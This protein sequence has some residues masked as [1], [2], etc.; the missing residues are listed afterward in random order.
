MILRTTL[1]FILIVGLQVQDGFAQVTRIRKNIL[2][3]SATELTSLRK[4]VEV[5]KSRP[6]SDPTSWAFQLAVHSTPAT[7]TNA[8][9]NQCEHGTIWFF[10]WHR[11]YIFRFEAILRKASGDPNLTLPYW[12]WTNNRSLP[13]SFRQPV[14]GG[15][16]NPLFH[17]ERDTQMNAGALLPTNVVVTDRANVLDEISYASFNGNFDDSPHGSIHVLVGG[18]T[19]DM[20]SVPHAALDPIFYLHHCNVDRNLDIWLNMGGGRQNPTDD[21][22]LDKQYSLADENGATVSFKVREIL[23]SAQ[24]EYRYDDTGNPPST[25]PTESSE[26]TMP[27]FVQLATS[28]TTGLEAGGGA[29]PLGLEPKE[30]KLTLNDGAAAAI[31][32]LLEAAAGKAPVFVEIEDISFDAMPGFTYAAYLNLPSGETDSER[33]DLHYLG[34]I[35]FFGKDHTHGEAHAHAHAASH[36]FAVRLKASRTILRLKEAGVWNPAQ[37]LVTLKP[38]TVV[39]SD[40]QKEAQNAELK[41]SSDAAKITIKRIVISGPKV[42]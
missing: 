3:L 36:K 32:S 29:I 11:A 21:D 8:L 10:A 12:D 13:S 33:A 9:H 19:G 27:Q 37:M 17:A 26:G 28:D 20:S 31:D 24:L 15:V 14:L 42:E 16:A 34:S 6:A 25:G 2:S 35:N 38:L 4:G 40:D 1:L 39:A 41:A 22:F 7:T 5:M 23:T 18:S 30:V